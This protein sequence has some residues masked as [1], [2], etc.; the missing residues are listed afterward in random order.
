MADLVARGYIQIPWFKFA[1]DHSSV[2]SNVTLCTILFIRK[3]NN[4]YYQF[5]DVETVFYGH[6]YENKSNWR[7]HR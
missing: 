3:I 1:K 6:L 4:L 7:F 2:V 5:T